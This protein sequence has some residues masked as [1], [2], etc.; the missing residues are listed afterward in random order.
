MA[1]SLTA[2]C[3]N[4]KD[5]RFSLSS[6][7]EASCAYLCVFDPDIGVSPTSKRIVQDVKRV[8]NAWWAILKAQGVYV[9]GL[10]GGYIARGRHVARIER[11][12]LR[13]GKRVRMEYNLALMIRRCTLIF[14]LS[15]TSMEVISHLVL[16]LICSRLMVCS[17]MLRIAW[18]KIVFHLAM[19]KHI[20]PELRH[21]IALSY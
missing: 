7:R 13:G 12:A 6:P 19:E 2:R 15:W 11:N 8:M 4:V 5:D 21:M 9:P 10:A 1:M 18:S 14:V 16:H 3:L 17:G 20:A